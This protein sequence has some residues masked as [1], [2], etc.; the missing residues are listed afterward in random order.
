[1][2]FKKI[3]QKIKDVYLIKQFPR[4]DNRGALRR[5]FCE[6]RFKDLNLIIKIKQINISQNY[7][8]HTLR[9]FHYYKKPNEEDKIVSCI[10]GSIYNIVLDLRKN[11]PTTHKWQYFQLSDSDNKSLF[12]PK[13]CANAYL[14]LEKN[15]WILYYHSKIYNPEYEASII[16]NDPYFKF[17]WPF[18]PKVISKKDKMNPFF[19]N[20]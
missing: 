15:T 19:K 9:G 7:S 20:L 5:H 14:T 18:K 13:G 16:Y 1:M 11:S 12:V 8:K 2:N 6:E 4:E 10:K 3:K 17:K